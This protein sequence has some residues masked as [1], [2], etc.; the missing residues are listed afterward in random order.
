MSKV[1]TPHFEKLID[2]FVASGRF[3][4]KSEVI[5]AGLRLLEEHEAKA[6]AASRDDLSRIIQTA[7]MDPRPMIPATE[8]LRRRRR[9]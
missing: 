3:N 5:R 7:L 1:I 6:A 9:Q 2:R 8:L 4:N